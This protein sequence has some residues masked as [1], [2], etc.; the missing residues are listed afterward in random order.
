MPS[1]PKTYR[2]L[3]NEYLMRF[4]KSF[5]V[6]F[7]AFDFTEQDF[8][9]EMTWALEHGIPFDWDS[10]RWRWSADPLPDDAVI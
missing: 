10:P 6:P 7:G 9:D 1:T 5:G 4:G 8:I 3:D 2:E